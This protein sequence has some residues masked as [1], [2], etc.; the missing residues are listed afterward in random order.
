MLEWTLGKQT[1]PS[2]PSN[3]WVALTYDAFDPTLDGTS[4]NEPVVGSYARV[5]IANDLTTFPAGSG[6]NPYTKANG[7]DIVFP[8]ATADYASDISAVYLVDAGTDG[9][10][11]YG[12]DLSST[13]TVADGDTPRINSGI[14]AVDEY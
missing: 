13:V 3:Y 6:G 12:C 14:F 11:W 5:E 2:P 4:L 10:I 8:E 1:A 7:I 9:D